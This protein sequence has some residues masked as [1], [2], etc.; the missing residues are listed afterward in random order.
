MRGGYARRGYNRTFIIRTN[1]ETDLSEKGI[2]GLIERGIFLFE[3]NN[4]YNEI[5][6]IR[7]DNDIY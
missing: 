7:I 5:D 2:I 4:I 3:E 1:R 6:N